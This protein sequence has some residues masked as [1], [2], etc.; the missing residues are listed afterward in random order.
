MSYKI[1]F[2][3]VIIA[4]FMQNISCSFSSNSSDSTSSSSSQSK[5]SLSSRSHSD[6]QAIT[7]AANIL[8]KVNHTNDCTVESYTVKPQLGWESHI[9][10][11]GH[12]IWRV[13]TRSHDAYDNHK[14]DF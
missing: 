1:I 14:N 13:N 9:I 3:I 10:K 4:G 12:K 8:K 2:G 5:L 11:S 7:T 6:E